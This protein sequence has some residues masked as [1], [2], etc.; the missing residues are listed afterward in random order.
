MRKTIKLVLVFVIG[1]QFAAAQQKT[2][3]ESDDLNKS[4]IKQERNSILKE[5]N[6]AKNGGGVTQSALLTAADVGDPDSFG[7]N[8]KFLGTAQTGVVIVYSSCDPAV[9]LA[10]LDIVLGA[11][12]RC[13]AA[14]IMGQ[15]VSGTFN[16]IGRITFPRNSADNVIYFLQ[17]NQMS[18]DFAN[19]NSNSV[20]ATFAYTPSYTIES[21]A[22][23]DPAAINPNTGLP[24]NGSFTTGISASKI[25]GKTYQANSQEFITDRYS[26]SATRGFARS[27]FAALGLP[28]HVINQ[29]YKNPI[30]IRLNLRVTTQFISYGQFFYSVRFTGN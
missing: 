20:F 4:V 13:L 5:F 2:A 11:D 8:V 10:D 6:E 1:I 24:M 14:P 25:T 28:Q 15:L 23:N 30:T 18:Y 16:D 3:V 27:Y 29:I 17:L 22:L 9:L 26:T 7:R 19:S 12:D 21:V